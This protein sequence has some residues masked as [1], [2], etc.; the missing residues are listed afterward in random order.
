MNLSTVYQG[1][2]LSKLPYLSITL[3]MKNW[4]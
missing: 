2:S 4:W 1:H 3:S